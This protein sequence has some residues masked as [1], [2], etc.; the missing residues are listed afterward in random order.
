M[1]AMNGGAFPSLAKVTLYTWQP[2][3]FT[4]SLA[5]QGLGVSIST[6]D[7]KQIA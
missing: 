7:C 5:L 1:A 2:T 6:Y 4:S 3:G